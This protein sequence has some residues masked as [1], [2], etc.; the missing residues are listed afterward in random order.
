MPAAGQYSGE[1]DMNDFIIKG[2]IIYSESLTELKLCPDSYLVCTDGICRG[3][4]ERIP[5]EYAG[6]ETVDDSG[7]LVV[8]GLSDLHLHA[9]QY[10]FR[11]MGM[12]LE[13]LDWLNTYAFP[14]ESS[15]KD[16]EYAGKAYS[17]F[18]GDLEK[19]PTTR[20]CI[21]A[22]IH[23]EATMMLM[24]MLEK[25]GLRGFVGKVNMDRNSPDY[26]VEKSAEDSLSAT[27]RWL[28]DSR[29]QFRNFQPVITPRFTI[30][31]SDDLM[32]MLGL[33]AREFNVRVQS[34]LSENRSETALVK[35]LCPW[36]GHYIDTYKRPGL[37]GGS[38]PSVMAHC[39]Y[40]DEYELQVMRD[41]GVFLAHCPQCNMNLASGLAPVRRWLDMGLNVGLG[42]DVAGGATLSIFRTMMEAMQTSRMVWRYIDSSLKPLTMEE[43]FF[44]GTKGGGAFF[45]KTG[46]FESGYSADLLVLDESGMRHPQ[47]LSLRQRLERFISLSS[48]TD[49]KHKYVQGRQLF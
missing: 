34:H 31:C 15:F 8:P 39:V 42:T 28:R 38:M 12:D 35:E 26:Y 10:S 17:I 29:E 46:S 13:L 23:P 6:L 24:E 33:A 7:S 25:T 9:P 21:F 32:N 20:A 18:A 45:G 1:T 49:I 36:A 19:S 2:D 14:E 16:R 3:V 43:V 40:S 27:V 44:L 4:F 11:G 48:S 37:I 30:S 47:P 22:T 5:E 41:N